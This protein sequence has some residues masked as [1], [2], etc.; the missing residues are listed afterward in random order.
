[1]R[2]A[3]LAATLADN[4]DRAMLFKRLATCV[5][6]RDILAPGDAALDS[7][8][9]RGPNAGFSIMCERLEVPNLLQRSNELLERRSQ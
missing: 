2:A 6:E 8:E 3:T 1:V 4:Y 9:W 7:L 5:V